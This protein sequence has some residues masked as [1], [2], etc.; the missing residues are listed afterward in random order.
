V[1]VSAA[2]KAFEAE[3]IQDGEEG[4][5]SLERTSSTT[6]P[7]TALSE[8]IGFGKKR[9]RAKEFTSSSAST[10]KTTAGKT[11]APEDNVELFD[12]MES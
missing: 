7:P 2:S 8:D 5:D 6:S 11:P 10:H 4:G 3:D 12:L 9:K 1:P